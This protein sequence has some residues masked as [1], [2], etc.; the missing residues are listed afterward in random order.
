MERA[1]YYYQNWDR[2]YENWKKKVTALIEELEAVN[3][4]ELPEM[5]DISVITEG[6]GVGSGYTLLK[7]YDDLINMGLLNWQYHFEFLISDTLRM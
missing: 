7:K 5:E 3:F 4:T 1:G 6:K 2:L